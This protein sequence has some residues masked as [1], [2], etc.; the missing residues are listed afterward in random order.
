MIYSILLYLA[1]SFVQ[2]YSLLLCC[3]KVLFSVM[4][5]P[6]LNGMKELV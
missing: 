5:T 1:F 6:V 3:L 2:L 4:R